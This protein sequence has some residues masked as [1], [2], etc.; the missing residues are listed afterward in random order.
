[1]KIRVTDIF[2]DWEYWIR[3]LELMKYDLYIQ[4]KGKKYELSGL[5]GS[6][7]TISYFDGEKIFTIP[8]SEV[9]YIETDEEI[10][11]YQAK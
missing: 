8:A 3:H 7:G 6:T 4:Y 9:E 1:M 5:H 10:E 11:G 2:D